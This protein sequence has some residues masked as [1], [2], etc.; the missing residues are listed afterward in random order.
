MGVPLRGGAESTE[1]P[2]APEAYLISALLESGQFNPGRYH[3]TGDDIEA[4]K[5]LYDFCADYQDKAGKAPPAELVARRFPEFTMQA[6]LDPAWAA[7]KVLRESAS[8]RLRTSMAESAI[9]LRDDQ[10]EEA[11]DVINRVGRP[12]IFTRE[13][14]DLFDPSVLE[15]RFGLDRYEV[16]WPTLQRLTKGG[17][18]AGELWYVAARL[19]N[20]KSWSLTSMAARAAEAGARVAFCS[21]EMPAG[22]I[23]ERLL[24]RLAGRDTELLDALRSEEIHQRKGAQDVLLGRTQGSVMIYDPSMGPVHSVEHAR[25]MCADY[26]IVFIDHVGL[27][28]SSDGQRA[29]NDWRVL[30]TISNILREVTLS[31]STPIVAAAQ[32]NREGERSPASIRPPGTKNLAGS[33]ALGQDADVVVTQRLLSRRVLAMSAEK[34]RN[35]PTGAWFARHEPGK[36][37]FEEIGKDLAMTMVDE[38]DML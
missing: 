30:A 8:R 16:P 2:H 35:G 12:R 33:D 10:V 38:D 6:G 34:V 31:T 32:V 13:P 3:V 37:R 22:D 7:D 15:G 9:R 26:D 36:G 14:A 5:R 23:A 28:H 29:V 20:G 19:A 25:W 18:L 11:Y 24:V 21:L 4:W 1:R 27:M 17:V